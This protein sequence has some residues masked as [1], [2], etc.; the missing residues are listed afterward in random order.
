VVK[1]IGAT[2]NGAAVA[3]SPVGVAASRRGVRAISREHG[4]RT[5]CVGVATR[6][7]RARLRERRSVMTLLPA[8]LRMS[9]RRRRF[10]DPSPERSRGAMQC[11]RARGNGAEHADDRVRRRANRESR[12]GVVVTGMNYVRAREG[13]SASR[14]SCGARPIAETRPRIVGFHIGRNESTAAPI[15]VEQSP[16]HAG[17]GVV[18]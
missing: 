4:G 2:G 10:S 3:A 14:A 11:R 7:V 12:E 9:N 13:F 15:S 8:E 16:I 5:R 18:V 6:D 17:E 1:S